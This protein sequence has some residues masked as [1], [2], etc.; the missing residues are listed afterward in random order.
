MG[1]K[2]W[3]L[4]FV[5]ARNTS[6]S[7]MAEGVGRSQLDDIAEVESAGLTANGTPPN[8]NGIAVVREE[9][10]VEFSGHR[11][12]PITDDDFDSL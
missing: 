8:P 4:L 3:R 11:S 1:L 7:P 9:L 6:R 5:C 2:R 10:G 12:R